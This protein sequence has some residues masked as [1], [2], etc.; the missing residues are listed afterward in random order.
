[1]IRD[2]VLEVF[3]NLEQFAAGEL[4]GTLS[5]DFLTLV[6]FI[7]H[8]LLVP[9]DTPRQDFKFFRIFENLF[10]FVIDSPV[11]S[12]PRSRDSPVYSSPGIRDSPVYSSPGSRDSPVINTP[13]SLDSLVYYSP[14]ISFVNLFLCLF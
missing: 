10:E 5:R 1:M 12:Q 14:E 6:F 9:L 7:K 3:R 13:G 2:F 11:Y 4:K 8:I